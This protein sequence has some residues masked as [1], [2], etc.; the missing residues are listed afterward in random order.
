MKSVCK[1]CLAAILT[2]A[3]IFSFVACGKETPPA[4]EHAHV[5]SDWV[6]ETEPTLDAEGS[7]YRKCTGC[8][9]IERESIVRHRKNKK[10]NYAD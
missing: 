7:K 3:A 10:S 1:L 2:F 5:Y 4:P 9:S 6:T 8:D